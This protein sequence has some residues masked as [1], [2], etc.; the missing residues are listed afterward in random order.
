MTPDAIVHVS[1][2]VGPR[3][4]GHPARIVVGGVDLTR[5]CRGF[6]VDAGVSAITDVWLELIGV[7][8]DI[9]ADVPRDRVQQ[10]TLEEAAAH[11][12]AQRTVE[13]GR[14]RKNYHQAQPTTTPQG[15]ATVVVG[16][17]DKD[18]EWR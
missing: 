15:T 12:E 9:E 14:G 4:I 7:S 18:A 13:T 6:K 11:E 17:G 10:M 5:H 2:S 3:G 8:V 16:L 1:L